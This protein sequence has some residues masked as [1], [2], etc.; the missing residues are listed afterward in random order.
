MFTMW[1]LKGAQVTELVCMAGRIAGRGEGDSRLA[2]PQEIP[3]ARP[4]HS[5]PGPVFT[6]LYQTAD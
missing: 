3:K 5:D 4:D 1:H 2:R 6:L